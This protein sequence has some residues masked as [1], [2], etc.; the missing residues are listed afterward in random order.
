MHVSKT[1]EIPNLDEATT[2]GSKLRTIFAEKLPNLS[3]ILHKN[4]L[5]CA[6]QGVTVKRRSVGINLIKKIIIN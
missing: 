1:F 6:S 4:E 2:F 3:K 5:Y